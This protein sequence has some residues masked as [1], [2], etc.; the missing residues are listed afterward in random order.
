MD[1]VTFLTKIIEEGTN[2]VRRSYIGQPMKLEGSLQGFEICRDKSPNEI[3]S[4]LEKARKNT[5]EARHD[6]SPAYWKVRHIELQIEWVANCIS[7]AYFQSNINQI[8]RP[9][10]R[11]Y[12]RV[13]SILGTSAINSSGYD[14]TN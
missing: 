3:A 1:Y 8:V 2:A 13:A 11:A 9:T 5:K 14:L 10:A 7:A 12:M 4:L 6:I